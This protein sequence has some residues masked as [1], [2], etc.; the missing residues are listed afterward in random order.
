MVSISELSN[1]FAIGPEPPPA[2]GEQEDSGVENAEEVV[3][4]EDSGDELFW[5]N[6]DVRGGYNRPMEGGR[7]SHGR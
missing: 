7:P 6:P 1:Y 5:K 3:V 4:Q 2:D